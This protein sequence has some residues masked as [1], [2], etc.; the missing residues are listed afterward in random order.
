MTA[1]LRS[2]REKWGGTKRTLL[3]SY[4]HRSNQAPSL[5]T[6]SSHR[7]TIFRSQALTAGRKRIKTAANTSQ[8]LNSTIVMDT[9]GDK[10]K[11]H[12]K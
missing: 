3:V 11:G 1:G 7:Y 12:D 8:D 5:F 10:H 2:R 6:Q 9:T 4:G